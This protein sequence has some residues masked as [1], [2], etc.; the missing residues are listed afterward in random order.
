MTRGDCLEGGTNAARPCRFYKCNYALDG[1]VCTLDLADRDGEVLHSE[2]GK[3]IGVTR[4]RVRQIEDTALKKLKRRLARE[5]I[6]AVAFFQT[7][8]TT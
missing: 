1:G 2:I 4:E 7:L 6:D 3:A 8:K 5:G